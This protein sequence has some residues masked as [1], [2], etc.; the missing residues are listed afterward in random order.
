VIRLGVPPVGLA[1]SRTAAERLALLD[2]LKV[3]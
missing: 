3:V 1:E 2:K